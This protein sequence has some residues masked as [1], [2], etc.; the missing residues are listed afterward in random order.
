M[1]VQ[2]FIAATLFCFEACSCNILL[3]YILKYFLVWVSWVTFSW[4]IFLQPNL[5]T[6]SCDIC[7]NNSSKIYYICFSMTLQL[8]IL[9]EGLCREKCLEMYPGII[10]IVQKEYLKI[11]ACSWS[12]FVKHILVIHRER[13]S[14]NMFVQYI[15]ER[16]TWSCLLAWSCWYILLKHLYATYSCNKFL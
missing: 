2:Y 15:L 14:W 10:S 16:A 11:F 7:K 12:M 6:C 9:M 5:G 13:F 1:V 3:K 8:Y 4:Y